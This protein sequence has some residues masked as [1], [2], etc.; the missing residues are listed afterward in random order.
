M[1]NVIYKVLKVIYEINFVFGNCNENWKL[2]F[3]D[4]QLVLDSNWLN[5]SS[6]RL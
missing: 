6:K 5:L 4:N 3:I 2:E 1:R